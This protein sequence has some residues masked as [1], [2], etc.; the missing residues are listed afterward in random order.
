M[1]SRP[2]RRKAGRRILRRRLPMDRKRRRA[3]PKPINAFFRSPPTLARKEWIPMMR[4]MCLALVA[5]L[6]FLASPA[7]AQ[8]LQA[9]PPL[10]ARV[11]DLTGTLTAEQ[12]SAMEQ[13]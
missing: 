10:N 6:A 9:V 2:R 1:A 13:K 11:T 3:R 7:F 4:T 5:V 8:D 12:Q